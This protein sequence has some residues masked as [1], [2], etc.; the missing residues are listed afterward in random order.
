M[1]GTGK[2]LGIGN[3]RWFIQKSC[4]F[5]ASIYAFEQIP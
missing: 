5:N 1:D 4:E 3:D 2:W